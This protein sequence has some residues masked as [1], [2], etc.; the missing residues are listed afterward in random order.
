MEARLLAELAGAAP[1]G[2]LYIA[3]D[4]ARM[5]ALAETVAFF[6][7]DVEV[8]R[9]PAW[10]CLPYDRTSP[11]AEV[12]A[13]RVDVL[14]RLADAAPA[15]H[16]RLIITTVSAALQR[17][18]AREILKGSS[19]GAAIGD[20]V[21]LDELMGFLV[22]NGFSRTGTVMEPGEY[23]QRGGLLDVFAPG[24]EAPLRLDFFGD[25]LESIRVFDPLTQRTIGKARRLDLGPVSELSLSEAAIARFRGAYRALFGAVT[26]DDPL[27]LAVS[28][29]RK[30]IGME[31]WLPLFHEA[32][33]TLFDYLPEALVGLD[34]LGEES[35]E[36]RLETIEDHYQARLTAA[37]TR[38]ADVPPYHPVPPDRLYLEADEWAARLAA[39]RVVAMSPFQAPEGEQVV[40]AGGRQGRNFAAEGAGR[41]DSV[42]ER[43]RQHIGACLASGRRV[44]VAAYTQ[45]SADRLGV[46]LGDH[47]MEGLE[48]AA[49][50]SEV[51]A[52]PAALPSLVVL[53]LEHGFE[54]RD[55]VVIGE[56]DILGD[57]M[58]RPG[59]RSR[60][61]EDFLAEASELAPQD[62]VVHAEHGIARYDGLVTIDV[63]GAPHDCLHLTYAGGDKLYLPVE[64]IELLSRYGSERSEA[65]L[66]KLGGAGWQARKARLK[67]RIRDMADELIKVA[68]SRELRAAP[69]IPPPEGLYES[70]CA[71]FPFDETEDQRRAIAEVFADLAKGRPMDRLVCG[72]VGFGKTEVALRS[73]FAT[74]MSGAQVAVVTPTTLLA[75]QHFQTFSERFQGLPV[76]VRQLSRLVPAREAQE[77]REELVSGRVDIVIGTHALLAKS[78][79]FRDLG[80]LV[81]D[82][83]QHFG[84]KHKERL[85]TLKENVHVL[86]LTATPIPRTLQMAMSGVKELSLI[87]TPPVDRLAVRTFVLPFDPVVVREAMLREHYR[88][89]QSF[90]VCPRIENLAEA[91]EFL[92]S[93]VPEV[94]FA[95]AHGRMPAT[96]LEEVMTAFYDG[97]YDVLVCTT[98]IESGLDIPS[99]NT[100]VVHRADMFGLAQ[101]YQLRGRIGRSKLRAY[102]YFTLPPRRLPT[103]TAEKRLKVL[104]ALDT[105]GAGFTLASHDLDIR[106]AGN[107]LGEE[108]S[109]HIREVGLEL[110]Q[111]M[112]EE[113]VAEAR[114]T[115][116][117]AGEEDWSPQINIG[118]SVLIPE[119]YVADLGVRLGLYRRLARLREAADLDSF[120]AELVDR[121]GPLPEEVGHLLE[122]VAI[123]QLCRKAVVAKVEA[124]PKGA[125]LSFHG[126]RFPDPAGLVAFINDQVGSAKLRPDHRLVYMRQW[127][128]AEDRLKGVRGLVAE[129][130]KVAQSPAA[131]SAA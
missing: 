33:E 26:G 102:A 68:A 40:D 121:F 86:T 19:F 17:V 99:A 77:T 112:L 73:A 52:R 129:L 57:R 41:D 36:A 31:H 62:F 124:G 61:A 101:L 42:F 98:I 74:V 96:A 120:A 117:D 69:E 110:Y 30:Q 95:T 130:A 113:A 66:D 71:R 109:G 37:E 56:Q 78:I 60:R 106:G 91:A 35:A 2:L 100:L 81:V 103:A 45:G 46:V 49:D 1:P 23:A 70:F 80:L 82:E 59:R 14:R 115:E 111:Q 6:A 114:G 94:K 67:A 7:P 34:H 131:S 54:A 8:L 90:Y 119:R 76:E 27:Y 25:E 85:K 122:I 10:D 9:F 20:S 51:T 12:A 43:L 75:R 39:S 65:V 5:S 108:Q 123:K 4:E 15:P 93:H 87:A 126:D 24:A 127:D 11:N 88:G 3:R 53:G 104:Q 118:T 29:G 89:G 79:R 64:N 105:L 38:I 18:P 44:V 47:G 84:V 48:A 32:M 116:P 50:W 128:T 83:E 72:D 125:T 16:G 58:V 63:G 13:R 21:P 97:A 22:R 107:L 55:L 28:E 92:R